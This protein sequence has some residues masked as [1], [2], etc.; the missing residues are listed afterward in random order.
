MPRVEVNELSKEIGAYAVRMQDAR[1]MVD[2]P[3][4]WYRY[5]IL[6]NVVH[7][8]AMLQG[9]YRDLAKL[10]DG[11]PVADIGAA[12]GDLAFTLE[13][14]ASW[15]V[16]IIDTAHSNANGLRGAQLLAD[17]LGSQAAIYDIDLDT[18][19]ELPRGRYGLVILLGILYHLKNPFYVLDHLAAHSNYCL[20]STR[21]ARFAGTDRRHIGDLS[22]AYLVGPTELNDDPT[23]FWVF[24]PAGLEQ[25]VTRAGWEIVSKL[26]VGAVESSVPD[27]NEGD[28]RMFMLLR[29]ISADRTTDE[30]AGQE[31]GAIN[32]G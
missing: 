27:S 1:A 17:V 13:A 11:M 26:N 28:E 12:D 24:T 15:D 6:A 9:E 7:L 2:E 22:L 5:D 23:N 21:V 10:A 31:D 16:D 20:L 30:S 29:S 18:Q 3:V 14:A 32:N 25:L 4:D 8:D 19:F